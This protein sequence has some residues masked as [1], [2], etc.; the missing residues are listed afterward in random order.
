MLRHLHNN[1]VETARIARLSAT[2]AVRELVK[3]EQEIVD[4]SKT[5]PPK[6]SNAPPPITPLSTT[7]SVNVDDDVRPG[8]DV[9]AEYR[10]ASAGR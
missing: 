4:K 2:A 8:K 1:K 7:G 9:I 5:Q 3:I 6:V 10:R